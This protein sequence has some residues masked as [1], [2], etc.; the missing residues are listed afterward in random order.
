MNNTVQIDPDQIINSIIDIQ[1][2][3][4]PDERTNLINE[5]RAL[6]R[7][8]IYDLNRRSDLP[9]HPTALMLACQAIIP[10]IVEELTNHATIDLTIRDDRGETALDYANFWEVPGKESEME[11]IRSMLLIDNSLTTKNVRALSMNRYLKNKATSNIINHVQTFLGP[12]KISKFSTNGRGNLNSPDYS[13]STDNSEQIT[14]P[15]TKKIKSKTKKNRLSKINKTR[16]KVNTKGRLKIK[17][18]TN[19]NKNKKV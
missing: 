19:K 9:N 3:L 16:R 1:A 7:S 13:Y 4:N 12:E 18:Y 6:I 17:K 14:T 11:A 8:N 5:T 2:E 10:E 15:Y